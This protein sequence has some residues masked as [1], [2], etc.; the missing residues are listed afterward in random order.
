MKSLKDS[1]YMILWRGSDCQDYWS[2]RDSTWQAYEA[3]K[4]IISEKGE[5]IIIRDRRKGTEERSLEAFEGSHKD[6]LKNRYT[7][8]YI[9]NE[10]HRWKRFRTREEVLDFIGKLDCHPDLV[11]IDRVRILAPMADDYLFDVNNI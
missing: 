11:D 3:L 7:V 1:R 10:E 9:E 6:E 5:N 4:Q 8:L 2:Y